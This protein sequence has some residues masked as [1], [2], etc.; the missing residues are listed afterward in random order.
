MKVR[1]YKEYAEAKST[2]ENQVEE[3]ETKLQTI[4][5]HLKMLKRKQTN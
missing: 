4:D 3:K 1:Q 5:D 2:I